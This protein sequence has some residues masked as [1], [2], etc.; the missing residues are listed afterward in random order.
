MKKREI[1]YSPNYLLFSCFCFRFC[2]SPLLLFRPLTD[3]STCH[4]LAHSL[5]ADTQMASI[6]ITCQRA[7][8]LIYLS[9]GQ[10]HCFFFFCA[11]LSIHMIQQKVN[12]HLL[13]VELLFVLRCTRICSSCACCLH[14]LSLSLSQAPCVSRC[15]SHHVN[16]LNCN[17][18]HYK[19]SLSNSLQILFSSS[20][21]SSS[22]SLDAS[23]KLKAAD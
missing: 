14:P 23:F 3:D 4:S 15:V 11:N 20:L 16:L 18:Q 10:S 7:E 21:S 19:V 22:L 2:L 9:E 17:H 13:P 8:V 12:L 1:T 6:K 5:F